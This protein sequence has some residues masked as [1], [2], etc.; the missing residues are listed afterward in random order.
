M[1]PCPFENLGRTLH[2]LLAAPLLLFPG[3]TMSIIF[4]S[5]V[6]HLLLFSWCVDTN[7]IFSVTTFNLTDVITFHF[8]PSQIRE[9][10]ATDACVWSGH[11]GNYTHLL[12]HSQWHRMVCFLHYLLSIRICD[13]N[14]F[15]YSQT[16]GYLSIRLKE[17]IS[18]SVACLWRINTSD[19]SWSIM[20]KFKHTVIYQNVYLIFCQVHFSFC[21]RWL[22]EVVWIVIRS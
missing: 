17:T 20:A 13:T 7:L 11:Q 8:Q 22:C 12:F 18:V 1:A 3:T 10:Q 21:H 5:E 9:A 15:L 19:C 4:L 6:V 16:M 2:H 14:K